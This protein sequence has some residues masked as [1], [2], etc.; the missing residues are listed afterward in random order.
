[1]EFGL[2][3]KQFP[4]SILFC[5]DHN[6]VRSPMAEGM[7][8]RFYGKTIYSQSAGVKND[9]E[10]SEGGLQIKN[11]NSFLSGGATQRSVKTNRANT[12]SRSPRVNDQNAT[13]IS[14]MISS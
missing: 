14:E 5:C 13:R 1:M 11:D 4:K 2:K 8:K 12:K 6:A 3:F 9:L 7:V 10:I